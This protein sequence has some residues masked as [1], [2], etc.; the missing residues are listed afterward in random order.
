M[1]AAAAR[2]GHLPSSFDPLIKAGMD[3]AAM[4]LLARYIEGNA[5]GKPGCRKGC[6]KPLSPKDKRQLA[7]AI[8]SLDKSLKDL[9]RQLMKKG[10]GPRC[11]DAVTLLAV[12]PTLPGSRTSVLSLQPPASTDFCVVSKPSAVRRHV[13]VATRAASR[14]TH[15]ALDGSSD[16]HGF[17]PVSAYT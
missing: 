17:V 4:G 13:F 2:T 5:R 1:H 8:K 3:I 15:D 6:R 12:F 9:V 14:D 10:A 16:G 7:K 11:A